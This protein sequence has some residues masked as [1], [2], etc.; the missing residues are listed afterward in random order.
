MNTASKSEVGCTRGVL[1]VRA[2]I[3]K[4]PMLLTIRVDEVGEPITFGT[5]KGDECWG[6]LGFRVSPA[7]RDIYHPVERDPWG[8]CSV[9]P[10]H[11]GL[12]HS[13]ASLLLIL[14]SSR[15]P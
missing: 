5:E 12:L 7:G 11:A 15:C 1:R 2:Q 10:G 14:L 3:P 13:D 9:R 4:P 6:P 8:L